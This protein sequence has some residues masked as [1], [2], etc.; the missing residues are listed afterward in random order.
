M[1]D[2]EV[3]ELAHRVCWKYKKADDKHG[4]LYTFNE[5]TLKEFVRLLGHIDKKRPDYKDAIECED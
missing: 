2:Y 4:D 5:H 3:R 1:T